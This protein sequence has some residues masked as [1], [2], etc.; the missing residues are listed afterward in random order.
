MV[1]NMCR[2][3]QPDTVVEP[4]MPVEVKVVSYYGN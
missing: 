2:P 1:W 4:V 3:Q